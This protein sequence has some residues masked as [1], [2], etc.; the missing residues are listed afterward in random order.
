MHTACSQSIVN[1]GIVVSVVIMVM[2]RID[3]SNHSKDGCIEKKVLQSIKRKMHWR[4]LM[5]MMCQGKEAD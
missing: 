1:T 3:D 4:K 2:V 5:K